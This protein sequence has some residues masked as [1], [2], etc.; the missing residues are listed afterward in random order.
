MPKILGGEARG[1]KKVR[2]ATKW[3]K[4]P[5]RHKSGRSEFQTSDTVPRSYEDIFIR[6][7]SRPLEL[8]LKYCTCKLLIVS[9]HIGD[10]EATWH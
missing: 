10:R 7:V 4:A 3:D 6:R 1:R 9:A 2:M 5:Y 8:Y